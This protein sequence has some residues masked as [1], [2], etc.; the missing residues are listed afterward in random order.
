MTINE[1]EQY[2]LDNHLEWRTEGA[3]FYINVP[4][5]DEVIKITPQGLANLKNQAELESYI[6]NG[7]N[8]DHIT[9]VTGYMS[10]VSG[11]NKGKRAELKDRHR[12]EVN[13]E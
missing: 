7:R 10:K 6:I 2:I 3:D 4:D 13:D 1:L 9:R 11:W 5:F 8:I 12:T